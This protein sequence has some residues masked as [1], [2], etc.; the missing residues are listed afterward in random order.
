MRALLLLVATFVAACQ[1]SR[2]EPQSGPP[3][4]GGG[5]TLRVMTYNVNYG[6]PGD[7]AT[8]EAI[9]DEGADVVFLQETTAAW[10]VALNESLGAAY[11]HRVFRHCC[12]AGGLGV[13]SKLALD[14]R[15]YLS[16]PEGGWFPAWRVIV[17]HESGDLQALVVHLRPQLSETGS[18]LGGV[19]TTP[20]I[21]RAEIETY[22]PALDP[23]LPTV[24]VGDFN[25]NQR[26]RAIRFLEDKGMQSAVP[27]SSGAT[28]T[29]RW[30]TSIGTIREQLDHVVVDGRVEVVDVRVL[31]RGSSDHLP[32]VATIRLR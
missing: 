10:E 11:P 3:D 6:I 18:F 15:E 21:R 1:D 26:G 29:W 31:E 28:P 9:V 4:P 7:P 25:E 16:P 19:F 24:I 27:S 14:A 22:F 32:V 23:S 17:H 20:P 12:G 2:P 8:V 13:L 5:P 30:Q